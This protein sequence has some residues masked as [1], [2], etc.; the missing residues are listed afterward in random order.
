MYCECR[1]MFIDNTNY[2]R[3]KAIGNGSK[4]AYIEN[5]GAATLINALKNAVL[6]WLSSS[7]MGALLRCI[8]LSI[9]VSFYGTV[10]KMGKIY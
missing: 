6:L 1:F 3:K 4:N 8:F 2:R 5:V 10:V 7:S 9:V